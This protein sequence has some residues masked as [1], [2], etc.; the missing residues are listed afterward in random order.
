[1]SIPEHKRRR[2]SAADAFSELQDLGRSRGRGPAASEQGSDQKYARVLEVSA[3][4]ASTLDLTEIL[5]LIVDGIIQ[6]TGCERGFLMLKESD[7]E[8]S[9]HIGR[10]RGE[11]EWNEEHL[12]IS[13]TI[14]ARVVLSREPF[15]A[16]DLERVEDLKDTD[17]IHQYAI[18]SAFCLPLLYKDELIG[19]IYADSGHVVPQVLEA[20]QGIL[21]AFAAQA[22]L[23]IANARQHGELKSRRDRLEEQNLSLRS[24][25]AKEFSF[26]GMVSKNKRMFE[27]FAT[28]EKVAPH[29][30]SVLIQGDSGTGK[31]LL[32]RG[33]HERSPR[34]SAPFEIVNC[35]AIPAG[36]VES[37][38]FGHKR[39][40]FTGAMR[41]KPGVFDLADNGTL[42]LDE[43]GD[44][45]LDVQPKLLRVLENGEFCRVGEEERVRKVEVRIIAATNMDL[46]RAVEDGRFRRDLFFRLNVAHMTLPPLRERPED[47]LPLAEHFLEQFA[48]DKRLPL[49]K[50]ARDTQEF[51]LG[52]AWQGN[53]RELRSS[54]EWAI[55]VQDDDH[56]IHAR[57]MRRYF[58]ADDAD[59]A[60]ATG[61]RAS[62]KDR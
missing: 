43:I 54:M 55:V 14:V 27:V 37:I 11:A 9:M 47:I 50:L 13:K 33:I 45:P 3:S 34:R 62:Y 32:A 48:T 25:L 52:R 21:A 56:V 17:S 26:S 44:M 61:A 30:L 58:A 41:D 7:G 40:A 49:P 20:D 6:V 39:G 18:R 10:T 59:P 53:V 12:A 57:E 19:V 46:A 29:D 42:F 51:L 38:L 24:Q 35:S 4:L 60:E 8:F 31:E 23:A 1:M 36:L 22:A 16:P 2:E 5:N 15:V 28:V